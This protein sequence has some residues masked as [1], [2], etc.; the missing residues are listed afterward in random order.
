MTLLPCPRGTEPPHTCRTCEVGC[1][2]PL[3]APG[4]GHYGCYGRWPTRA[5]PGVAAEEARYAALLATKR[6]TEARR[7]TARARL[8][9]RFAVLGILSW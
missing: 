3:D 2:C 9:G 7:L 5:C 1:G 8:S 4:C 6:R